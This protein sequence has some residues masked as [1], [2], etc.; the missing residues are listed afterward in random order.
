M[1]LNR[2]TIYPIGCVQALTSAEVSLFLSITKNICVHPRS[3]VSY[4]KEE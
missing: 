3:S 4:F 1:I 2:Q